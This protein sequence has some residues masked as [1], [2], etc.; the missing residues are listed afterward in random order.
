LTAAAAKQEAF[1]ESTKLTNQ[2]RS[3]DEDEIEFLDSVQERA[4]AKELAE[5]K[6]TKEHLEEFRKQQE[7]AERVAK[8]LDAAAAAPPTVSE[9]WAVGSRKR[10]KGKEKDGI[11]GLK[12]RKTSTGDK[13]KEAVYAN[14]KDRAANSNRATPV[15]ADKSTEKSAEKVSDKPA[16]PTSPSPPVT[17]AGLGLGAYSSDEE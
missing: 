3:L 1:E 17:A 16:A 4:R 10:K 14:T 8:E 5:K 6:H 2:F 13:A 12:I 11:G 9:T 7:E 15:T